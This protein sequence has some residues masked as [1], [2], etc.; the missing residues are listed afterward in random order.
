[1]HR[2]SASRRTCRRGWPCE[3]HDWTGERGKR[4]PWMVKAKL[5]GPESGIKTSTGGHLPSL[6]AAAEIGD[7]AS[8]YASERN[9]KFL[10]RCWHKA[11]PCAEAWMSGG[12][13]GG[14]P[15]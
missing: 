7:G 4:T 6:E 9:T 14:P 2:S 1:M 13:G 5:R 3:G 11:Y 10:P 15:M 12:G 8:F